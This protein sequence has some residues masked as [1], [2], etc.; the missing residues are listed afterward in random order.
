MG[1]GRLVHIVSSNH[2]GGVES[3]AFDICRHYHGQGWDVTA[4]TRDAKAVDS[5]FYRQGIPLVHAPLGGIYD[6]ASPWL[7]AKVIKDFPPEGGI[8]H[9][10]KYSDA[11]TALLARRIAGRSDVKIVAT[12]H[13]VRPGSDTWMFRKL[14]SGIDAHI[15]VSQTAFDAFAKSWNGRSLPIPEERLHI[16]RNSLDIDR[17]EP[18]PEPARGPVT[19]ICHGTIVAG[20]GFEAIIDALAMIRDVK[21]RLRI[22]GNGNPDY[23]DSLRQRAL[24][25][26]V[27][28]QIDWVIPAGD[29]ELLICE[30]H[31]GV[32]ASAQREGFAL[33]SLRYM[34]LGRPQVCVANGAQS[35]YL[36]D[37]RSALFAPPADAPRLAE[38][39]RRLA[40]DPELRRTLG[41]NALS[42]FNDTHS[43][44]EFISRLDKI[45]AP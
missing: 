23:I 14:C 8:V 20:K 7:L 40:V 44:S 41:M 35:E 18:L 36:A 24:A 39:I 16:L 26:G 38:A 5:H 33:E 31:F 27:M 17:N 25:R 9:V 42:D 11:F 19:A 13:I 1:S 45:Y 3:Y 43:W 32:Q 29:I 10:H 37:G 22:A 4:V 28:E 21:V 12:R 34:A 6:P 30:S 2:W 15:F